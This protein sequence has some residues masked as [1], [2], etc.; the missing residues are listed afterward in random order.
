M[1]EEVHDD[2]EVHLS[3]EVLANKGFEFLTMCFL[4]GFE[5]DRV[6]IFFHSF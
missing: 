1:Y 6:V 3:S 5:F 2:D 4:R